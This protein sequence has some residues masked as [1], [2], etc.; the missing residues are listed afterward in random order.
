MCLELRLSTFQLYVK[1]NLTIGYYY[2]SLD[3]LGFYCFNLY[4][5][6]ITIRVINYMKFENKLIRKI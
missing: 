4:V 5:V 6:N 2:D 3:F 1:I